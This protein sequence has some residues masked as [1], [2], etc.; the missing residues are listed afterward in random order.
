MTYVNAV[1]LLDLAIL[2]SL[3]ASSIPAGSPFLLRG[4]RVVISVLFFV[5]TLHSAKINK[6]FLRPPQL[7]M[8]DLRFVVSV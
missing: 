4:A 8:F 6:Q 5:V 3:T 7:C 1:T 2:D